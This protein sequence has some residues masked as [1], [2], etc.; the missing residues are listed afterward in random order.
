MPQSPIYLDYNAT[1]PIRPEIR[2]AMVEVM[3]WPA[4][5]SSVHWFGREAKK[6]LEQARKAV[7]DEVSC[8][9]QEIV[10]T[11]SGTESNNLVLNSFMDRRIFTSAVEHSSV[12]Q[13]VEGVEL[14]PVDENG[15][16]NI[17]VLSDSIKQQPSV[18][19]SVMLANNETG[20]IQ[21]IREVAEAVHA[22]GGLLHCDAV[23]GL[24][25]MTV[26]MGLLGA[27]LMTVSAHKM[28]GPPGVAAVIARQGIPLKRQMRGGGQESGRRA[29]TENIAAITGFAKA[30]DVARTDSWQQEMRA[31]LD[32]MERD[33]VTAFPAA[34]VIGHGVERLANTSSLLMPGVSAE[35]QLMHF[36]LAGFAVSA[37]S[38]CSSGRIE[39][40]HVLKAMGLPDAEAGS[41]I[42]VST[43]WDTQPGDILAFTEAWK[44]FYAKRV[45]A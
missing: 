36:D 8:F 3:G 28:G 22:I 17:S 39:P 14:L 16:I 29:G 9:P 23:Q 15:I 32:R 19:V 11:A 43:G 25:K 38:A 42:R 31:R 20:V 7:A 5:A 13:A 4:N 10:F 26:D 24:G 21:P 35:T 44:A 34:K 30:I 37:G 1:A 41:V 33:I 2:E 18:L 27:D 45:A 12:L 6:W 40:S